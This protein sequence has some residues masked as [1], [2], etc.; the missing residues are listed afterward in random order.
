MNLPPGWVTWFEQRGWSAVHWATVG[1][2]RAPDRVI[3]GW[4]RANGQ[5]LF[6]HDLD[7]GAILASAGA[8][9]PSVVQLRTNDVTPQASGTL[10]LEVLMSFETQLEKGA[11]LTVDEEGSRVR[12]LPLRLP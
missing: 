11:L 3:L 2:P 8:V 10:V 9:S 12:L 4:A 6:T 1:D 7:F 5:V